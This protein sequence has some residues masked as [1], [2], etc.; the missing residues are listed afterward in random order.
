MCRLHLG[1]GLYPVSSQSYPD[2]LPAWHSGTALP[3]YCNIAAAAA[4]GLT[5][6]VPRSLLCTVCD[7]EPW[8]HARHRGSRLVLLGWPQWKQAGGLFYPGG[9]VCN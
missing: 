6:R 7:A 9:A 5:G 4:C 8:L 3:N 2:Y 1:F